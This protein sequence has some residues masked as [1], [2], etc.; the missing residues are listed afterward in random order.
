MKKEKRLRKS[1]A[2]T[3]EKKLDKQPKVCSKCGRPIIS[4]N[5]KKITIDSSIMRGNTKFIRECMFTEAISELSIEAD[6]LDLTL[7]EYVGIKLYEYLNNTKDALVA[8][9]KNNKRKEKKHAKH[10]DAK[11]DRK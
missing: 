6:K 11:R 7:S 5:R 3:A 10:N 8:Q 9:L 4:R 2:K 1:S